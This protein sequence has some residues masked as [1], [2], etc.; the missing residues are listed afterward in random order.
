MQPRGPANTNH[1]G[2]VEEKSVGMTLLYA[3][4]TNLVT[5]GYNRLCL[6]KLEV[7]VTQGC[8]QPGQPRS[9]GPTITMHHTPGCTCTS[10]TSCNLLVVV[11]ILHNSRCCT[12]L[13][14]SHAEHASPVSGI[15]KSY[16][17]EKLLEQWAWQHI[18]SNGV[19]DRREDPIEL[20]Q[21]SLA[22]SL[23]AVAVGRASVIAIV[24]QQGSPTN[25]GASPWLFSTLHLYCG[26]AYSQTALYASWLCLWEQAAPLIKYWC[27]HNTAGKHQAQ[28]H[29]SEAVRVIK[30]TTLL[31]WLTCFPGMRSIN[32][33]VMPS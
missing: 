10:T 1:E 18:P 12:A 14:A 23:L 27:M 6:G 32:S 31:G 19:S 3:L 20:A 22:V 8:Q 21:G 5:S 4:A 33:L 11:V 24:S 28:Q 26:A 30:Q 29:P 17:T 25:A 13:H 2:L 16:R 15:T 9:Q 7:E